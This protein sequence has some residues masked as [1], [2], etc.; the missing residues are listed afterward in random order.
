VDAVENGK[1]S[2]LAGRHANFF[3][4]L[5]GLTTRRQTVSILNGVLLG[6]GTPGVGT[7]YMRYFENAALC[8]AGRAESMLE[9]LRAYWGGMLD[10]GATTF[11]EG[12]DPLEHDAQH[13]AFY[14]RPFARSLCHA[15]ASGPLQLLS[16]DLV[17]LKPVAPGWRRLTVQLPKIRLPWIC[18]SVPTPHGD[19]RWEIEGRRGKIVT[20]DGKQTDLRGSAPMTI[21]IS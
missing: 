16:A 13:L 17:G 4:L 6:N 12:F 11:W 7:P 3:A 15:W 20:P 1:Q 14:G 18:A 5:A 21:D 8:K 19:I 10:L 9:S 2:S